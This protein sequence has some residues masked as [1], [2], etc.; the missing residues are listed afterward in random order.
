MD[1]VTHEVR[2]WPLVDAVQVEADEQ[3]VR[4]WVIT[5]GH[6]VEDTM[7]IFAIPD[8]EDPEYRLTVMV[9]VVPFLLRLRPT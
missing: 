1:R 5:R 2:A 6:T 8:E 9:R 7:T 3:D 4:V